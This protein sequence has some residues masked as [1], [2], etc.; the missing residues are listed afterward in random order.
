[1]QR[2]LEPTDG[3]GVMPLA[4]VQWEPALVCF[5][6]ANGGANIR[7]PN[8]AACRVTVRNVQPTPEMWERQ[9]VQAIP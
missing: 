4:G 5:R 7:G 8:V 2:T 3:L 6:G 1:M 9:R